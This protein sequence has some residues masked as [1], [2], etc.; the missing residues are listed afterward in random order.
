[1]NP[2][3]GSPFDPASLFPNIDLESILE[4]QLK[5][6]EFFNV[7][8]NNDQDFLELVWMYRKVADMVRSRQ[9]HGAVNTMLGAQ[10]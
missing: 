3:R 9:D 6:S 2:K 5:V 7:Q 10:R 4:M 1:M 8:P